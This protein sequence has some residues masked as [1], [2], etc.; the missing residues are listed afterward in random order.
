[1]AK[2]KVSHLQETQ[3]S[4]LEEQ[5]HQ[6]EQLAMELEF[7]LKSPACPQQLHDAIVDCLSEIQSRNDC[8]N[9]DF[10]MGLLLSKPRQTEG[11][12]Q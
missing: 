11:G 2:A 6:A 1:M 7:V 9:V 8:Y 5:R 3:K 10:L 4:D 12:A